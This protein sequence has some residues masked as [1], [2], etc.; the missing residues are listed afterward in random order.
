[1][2]GLHITGDLYDCQCSS[3]YL[4]DLNVIR[5][6]CVDLVRSSGLTY[7]DDKFFP[8]P[9]WGGKPGGVSGCILLAESHLAIHTWPE[10]KGVTLDVYVCNFTADN[11]SRCEELFDT[12]VWVFEPTDIGVNRILR[13]KP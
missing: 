4:E 11:T 2:Q 7:V 5:R 13:G 1:M 8:F 3:N 9:S 6:T 10:R 12:L